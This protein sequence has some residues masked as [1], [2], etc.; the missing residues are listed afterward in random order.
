MNK[1]S[2][3]GSPTGDLRVFPTGD[4]CLSTAD[5]IAAHKVE[6]V[7]IS[8]P[9][10]ISSPHFSSPNMNVI[11]TATS[12]QRLLNCPAL[13]VPWLFARQVQC[14]DSP[15]RLSHTG[16]KHIDPSSSRTGTSLKLELQQPCLL[17]GLCKKLEP[18]RIGILGTP[19][20]ELA[21]ALSSDTK[22]TNTIN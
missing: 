19:V 4:L 10:V 2:H 17:H 11:S 22:L 7:V 1:I 15:F 9:M 3:N 21:Q 20:R 8:T 13:R 12:R 16:I 6:G 5:E 14:N 18:L